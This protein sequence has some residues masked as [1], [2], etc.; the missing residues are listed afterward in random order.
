MTGGGGGG[1]GG[2]K[3]VILV[4]R[5]KRGM[6]ACCITIILPCLVLRC[7]TSRL[8]LHCLTRY[9]LYDALRAGRSDDAL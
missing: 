7:L 8:T 4:I 5:D 2:G 3:E 1:G 6:H 9:R